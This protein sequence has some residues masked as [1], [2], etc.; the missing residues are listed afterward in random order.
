M[1]LN[2]MSWIQ[3]WQPYFQGAAR[4]KGRSLYAAGA[5]LQRPPEQGEL[6]RADVIDGR[7]HLVVVNGRGAA[8][9]AHCTCAHGG[10]G[11]YCEHIWAALLAAEDQQEQDELD[12]PTHDAPPQ[13]PK[14]RKR[15][16]QRQPKRAE[17]K[18][19]SYLTLLRPARFANRP[20]SNPTLPGTQQLVYAVDAPLSEEQ[21]HLVIRVFQRKRTPAGW[22]RLKPFKVDRDTV[23]RLEQQDDR[24]LCGLLVGPAPLGETYR[25]N[26]ARTDRPTETFI[27]PR[28][29]RRLLLQRII[30]TGRACV[31]DPDRQRAL[32]PQ[33]LRWQTQPWTLWAKGSTDAKGMNIA[34]QIR[35]G[36]EHTPL[37][38]PVLVLPGDDGIVIHNNTAAPLDDRAATQWVQQFRSAH[39]TNTEPNTLNVDTHDIP[40]FIDRLYRL[41]ALPELDIPNDV[42]PKTRTVKPVP[43]M[44]LY[45][46]DH[47]EAAAATQGNRGLITAK[48]WFDYDKRIISPD[49]TE[50]FITPDAAHKQNQ[51]SPDAPTPPP[52]DNQLIRRDKTAEKQLLAQ[53]PPLGFQPAN[54]DAQGKVLLP[55]EHV[56]SAVGT[57]IDQGWRVSADR[58]TVRLP[59]APRLSVKSGIDW[60][61][62]KGSI[63]YQTNDGE[64]QIP[65][66]SILQAL[67]AGQ[68]AVTLADG[69][70]G[71][72]PYKWLAEH[73]MIVEIGQLCDDHIRFEGS[74][75]AMLDVLLSEQAAA[76]DADAKF[77]QIRQRLH[78][79]TTIDP[80]DQGELFKGTLRPYQRQGLGWLHFLAQV[81]L[82]GI[83]ADDMG[84]GKTIQVLAMLERHYADPQKQDTPENPD[85]QPQTPNPSLIIVPSS[86]VYNWIDEAT[87]FAPN[88][89]LQAYR[90]TDRHMLRDAFT[91]HDVVVTSYGLLRR[92]I[93]ALRHHR[94]EFVIL[95]EAQ[96]IKNPASQSA[97]SARLLDGRFKIA[98]TGTPIENHLGDLWS[99]FEFLNPG[100]LGSNT[101]FARMVRAAAAKTPRNGTPND[102]PIPD[103][104]PHLNPEEHPD[105]SHTVQIAR[106]LRPFILRR[107]KQQV[108]KDLP[109]KT[110][111]TIVCEMDPPQRKIYD[112]LLRHYRKTLLNKTDRA[113][114]PLADGSTMMVLEALLRLRQAACHPGLIDKQRADEPSAKFDVLLNRLTDLIEEGQKA[115][116]FSQFTKLLAL[117]KTR[118]D[119]KK[120][121]Y[122]Y[123]DGQTRK[124]KECIERFQSDPD[125]PVFLI[126]LKAGGLGLNLTAAEYVFLLDPWWNPAVEAQA[127]DRAHRIGQDKHVFA[128][129]LICQDTVEQRIAELQ[130]GKKALA[131]AVVGGQDSLLKSLTRDDLE[132]LLT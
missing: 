87:K 2:G 132:K 43:H 98:L 74:Q 115:L 22:S 126:S 19:E 79:F 85:Q 120:I 112:E 68:N 76:T 30:E 78:G 26:T 46:P 44:A 122:E 111:Q 124:R 59:A 15:T 25:Q 12:A 131:D 105:R 28:H 51:Q 70:M 31:F 113:A 16:Q 33:P 125:C 94:F 60:F 9:S 5:V 48:V 1:T 21:Q 38:A 56:P 72:L 36:E 96:A 89:R 23:A 118:L 7:R 65:L 55:A 29:G 17:A 106:A 97:K 14:A 42:K 64:E 27:L 100:M 75:A 92:D 11:A 39:T 104:D 128:Y 24:E 93:D 8:T 108:L 123:L 4:N 114:S 77:Q 119:R 84:L 47:P 13:L 37:N 99:I 57:L 81:G 63:T 91:D 18:W 62:L 50:S 61:E 101:G 88:L 80:V 121:T 67:H 54:D 45:S 86:V 103:D 6:I 82:G 32:D 107:T 71:M 69:S 116:V 52:P 41:P 127:I 40:K 117:V 95:D 110:E 49:R 3:S 90:G 83:L 102:D 20:E 130:A 35:R 109:P 34:V 129:R 53:L 10:K 73:G 58:H 66:P